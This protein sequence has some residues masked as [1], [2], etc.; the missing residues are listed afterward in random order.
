M[1]HEGVLGAAGS[2][3]GGGRLGTWTACLNMLGLL[4]QFGRSALTRPISTTVAFLSTVCSSPRAWAEYF[5][6]PSMF[7]PASA[8]MTGSCPIRERGCRGGVD[9]GC[10][11]ETASGCLRLTNAA[12]DHHIIRSTTMPKAKMKNTPVP[13]AAESAMFV[14]KT[15][16]KYD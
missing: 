10:A 12:T 3:A 5:G 16:D 2:Y 4:I 9:G 14:T 15:S 8:R 11:A 1:D 7:S 13:V 6:R